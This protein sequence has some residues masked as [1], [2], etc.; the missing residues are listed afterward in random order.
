MCPPTFPQRSSTIC[1][2]EARCSVKPFRFI[3]SRK[4]RIRSPSGVPTS[5]WEGKRVI[6]KTL[7]SNGYLSRK[8]L[9]PELQAGG[10][11]LGGKVG[12]SAS[13]KDA[14]SGVFTSDSTDE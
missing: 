14:P 6:R 12:W 13:R 1:W 10:A 2:S 11:R 9:I 3:A 8:D 5:D 7:V 4:T